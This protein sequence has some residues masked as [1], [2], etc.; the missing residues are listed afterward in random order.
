[1]TRGSDRSKDQEP[2][3]SPAAI[4]VQTQRQRGPG[5]LSL[6]VSATAKAL[7][8]SP[9]VILLATATRLIVISNY[10]TATATTIAST[11]GAVGTLLGT[12]IPLLPA[13]FP[14]LFLALVLY[15]KMVLA[16]LAGVATILVS[17]A[18]ASAP[19][20]LESAWQ[21]FVTVFTGPAR[22]PE[23]V[24]ENESNIDTFPAMWRALTADI[25]SPGDVVDVAADWRIQSTLYCL[26]AFA[27]AVNAG[28][29]WRHSR[30]DRSISWTSVKFRILPL[31]M[32]VLALFILALT[33]RMYQLPGE[34]SAVPEI[35]Q[36]PWL[37]PEKVTLTNGKSWIGYTL[38]Y[39]DGWHVLLE[40][41]GRT[42]LY[43]RANEV[44]SRTVCRASTKLR[45]ERPPL[46]RLGPP[47]PDGVPDCRQET[48]RS[49]RAS[50]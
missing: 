10:D 20:A 38:S 40:D 18:Y 35:V 16:L 48:A 27:L 28:R 47:I 49:T 15:R 43:F 17:P 50:G 2:P 12:V 4:P 46:I 37:P 13:F 24:E 3:A 36:Q 9:I 29:R 34:P 22:L 6:A 8:A 31:W 41:Q 30:E 26:S 14:V 33:D 5:N 21:R 11:T 42:I 1:M 7:I 19:E 39:K 32:P 23:W 25:G 45:A 44:K